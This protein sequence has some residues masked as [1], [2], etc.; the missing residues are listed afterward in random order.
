MTGKSRQRWGVVLTYQNVK[1]QPTPDAVDI[2]EF[3]EGVIGKLPSTITFIG[4]R[5]VVLRFLNAKD[6]NLCKELLPKHK[7]PGFQKKLKVAVGDWAERD[8]DL[9]WR[10]ISK[11]IKIEGL[12][13]E[14]Q[15]HDIADHIQESHD[16]MIPLSDIYLRCC[17][18][19]PDRT[20]RADI[21][22][23][24][25]EAAVGL[26]EAL[27]MNT[28]KGTKIW[29]EIAKFSKESAKFLKLTNLD[30]KVSP[31][32]I[33]NLIEKSGRM[34]HPYKISLK[35]DGKGTSKTAIVEFGSV[36][37]AKK[38]A[39]ST[40]WCPKKRVPAAAAC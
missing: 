31:K 23:A 1:K 11:W 32:K 6:A 19:N 8:D 34:K 10:A 28:L 30:S 21:E 40:C 37:D 5:R 18:A 2:A 36:K 35:S 14:T 29:A 25:H 3:V 27:Q 24:D 33:S 4:G 22:C 16:V 13:P 15:R 9:E 20:I 17:N 38:A 39:A 7:I 12:H 26:V